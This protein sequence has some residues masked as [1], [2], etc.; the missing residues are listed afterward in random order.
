VRRRREKV[1]RGVGVKKLGAARLKRES[2]VFKQV[3]YEVK[4][5]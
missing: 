1:G 2:I 4:V 5:S 3:P